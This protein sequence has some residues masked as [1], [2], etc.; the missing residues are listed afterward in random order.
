MLIGVVEAQDR[1]PSCGVPHVVADG[2]AARASVLP[3]SRTAH[4]GAIV[5]ACAVSRASSSAVIEAGSALT[6]C[7]AAISVIRRARSTLL[8]HPIHNVLG[9]LVVAVDGVV[10]EQ[11]EVDVLVAHR[12]ARVVAERA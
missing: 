3:V 4:A 10:A 6:A 11:L 5:A 9:A 8:G 12:H 2:P 7:S 1:C